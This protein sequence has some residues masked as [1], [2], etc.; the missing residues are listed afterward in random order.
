M[1]EPIT[2]LGLG[3]IAAYLGKDG[4]EKLLGPT[5]EYLG[6]GLRDLAQKRIENI[7]RILRNAQRK[8]G[9]TVDQPGE[10]SPR[11]LRAV[12]NEGSYCDDELAAEY[13]GGVLASSRTELGRDDRGARTA[14]ILDGLSTYQ[15]R[16]HYL[17]YMT[18]KSLFSYSGLSLHGEDRSKMQIFMPAKGYM[19]AMDFNDSEAAQSGQIAAHVFFG[20][21]SEALIEGRWQIS[22]KDSIR[23]LY[24]EAEEDGIVCQPSA[25]GAELFLWAFGA[26][27]HSLDFIFDPKF[28]PCVPGI[29]TEVEGAVATKEQHDKSLNPD[30][31]DVG[32]G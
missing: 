11:V 3:A 22:D 10:V 7:G 6:E 31:G 4:L 30:T 23:K 13:F 32:A 19:E 29:P 24:P 25:L 14:K 1:P 15:I 26:A 9:T 2:T 18:I 20:L 28:G 12:L 17:I 8:L 16:T 27:E 5:A 21:D